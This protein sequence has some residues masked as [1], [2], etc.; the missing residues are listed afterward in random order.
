MGRDTGAVDEPDGPRLPPGEYVDVPG[1]GRMFFRRAAGP[2]GSPTVVLLH[3]LTAN[4]DLNWFPSYPALARH[5]TVIGVDHRGHGRG[6]R[7]RR[8]F[9]LADCADDVAGLLDVLGVG[10][11]VAT[12]YSMGGPVAQLLWLRHRH[13]VAGL[14]FCATSTHFVRATPGTAVAWNALLGLSLA[15][16]ATPEAV[17]RQLYERTVAS[18]FDGSPLARWAAAEVRRSDPSTILQATSAVARF[19]SRPWIDQ[20]DVPTAVVVTQHDRLVPSSRQLHLA[21]AV[22]GATIHPVAG[23]HGVCVTGPRLFV[24]ALVDA[25]RSVSARAGA[26][27]P[28]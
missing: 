21:E 2:P 24:P 27:S 11:V 23:D 20:V 14:V 5:A 3:G 12:G 18:R 7:S 10:P 26:P 16:S 15:A 8:R 1:R 6:I 13:H 17:R 9:R 28:S 4:C 22:P 25:V 19:D